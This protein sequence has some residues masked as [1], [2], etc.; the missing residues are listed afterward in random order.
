MKRYRFQMIGIVSAIGVAVTVSAQAPKDFDACRIFTSTD[1]EAALGV[2]VAQEPGNA[3][4]RPKVTLTCK[5]TAASGDA[6]SA[7][8]TFRFARNAEEAKSAYSESRLELRGKPTII[9]GKDANWNE[10]LGQLN[11]LS[12]NVWLVIDVGPTDAKARNSALA[13]KLAETLIPKL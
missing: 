7:N 13:K 9:A 1:A 4:T 12:G 2:P 8:V 5:Y 11:V 6:G 3:K 10:K